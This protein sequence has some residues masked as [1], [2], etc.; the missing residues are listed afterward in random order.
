MLFSANFFTNEVTNAKAVIKFGTEANK[1]IQPKVVAH[2][3]FAQQK[4]AFAGFKAH[5]EALIAAGFGVDGKLPNGIRKAIDRVKPAKDVAVDHIVT[6]TVKNSSELFH[7]VIAGDTAIV[8]APNMDFQD[9]AD[10]QI[11]FGRRKEVT[12]KAKLNFTKSGNP[13]FAVFFNSH[14]TEKEVVELVAYEGEEKERIESCEAFLELEAQVN[15]VSPVVEDR[16]AALEAQIAELKAALEEKDQII[17][18]QKAEIEE[19]KAKEVA[20]VAVVENAADE[21]ANDEVEVKIDVMRDPMAALQL[22]R[23]FKGK[24]H[25]SS[26]VEDEEEEQKRNAAMLHDEMYGTNFS[27]CQ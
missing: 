9:T 16:F 22:L 19:L 23:S 7:L 4:S 18:A 27:Y 1:K 6:F 26:D 15:A 13:Y 20:P 10:C 25:F 3:S 5:R 2:V 12:G 11:T 24:S 14:A 21:A 17:E 8:S